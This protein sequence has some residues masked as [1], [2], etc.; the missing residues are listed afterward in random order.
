MSLA[1]RT[2]VQLVT[3]KALTLF[4]ATVLPAVLPITQLQAL[5]STLQISTHARLTDISH[6]LSCWAQHSLFTAL[7][8][9]V[10]DHLANTHRDWKTLEEDSARIEQV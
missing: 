10:A 5:F 8:T 1:N 4:A 7:I 6:I 2:Y 3:R 9:P